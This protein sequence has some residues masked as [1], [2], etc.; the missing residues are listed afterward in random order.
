M[1][2]TK[3][4]SDYNCDI[5]GAHLPK[6]E[7][8]LSE[9]ACKTYRR[10]HLEHCREKFRK[11]KDSS[12]CCWRIAVPVCAPVCTCSLPFSVIRKQKENRPESG[13][14]DMGIN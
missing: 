3:N 13:D 10:K 4:A 2:L 14:E 11:P 8:N 5:H 7:L 9:K 6:A 12:E 1:S